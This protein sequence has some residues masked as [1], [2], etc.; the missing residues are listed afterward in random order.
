MII[1]S[2]RQF[3]Q[4]RGGLLFFPPA[5]AL[6]VVDA[7]E[8]AK[9]KIW[10]LDAF[11]LTSLETQPISEHSLDFSGTTGEVWEQ[12]KNF[13]NEKKNTGLFFEVIADE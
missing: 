10:G 9:V 3:A 5:K 12:T 1:E 8:K 13:L 11:K 4:Q 7:L 6:E 2:F